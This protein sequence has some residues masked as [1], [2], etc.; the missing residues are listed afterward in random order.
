MNLT[1]KMI[2]GLIILLGG[3]VLFFL[4]PR[5]CRTDA[6]V[7]KAKLIGVLITALGAAITFIA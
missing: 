1:T 7:L 2:P 3:A 5:I 6:G 4:S